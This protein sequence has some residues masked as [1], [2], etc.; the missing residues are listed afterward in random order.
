M[1]PD[2]GRNVIGRGSKN[3]AGALS[4]MSAEQ[5]QLCAREIRRVVD[6]EAQPRR[7][8]EARQLVLR[9][10]RRALGHLAQRPCRDEHA[11]ESATAGRRV[12]RE[13]RLAVPGLRGHDLAVGTGEKAQ[14]GRRD[15]WHVHPERD[16]RAARD[17]VERSEDPAGGVTRQRGLVEHFAIDGR[18][19]RATLRDDDDRQAGSASGGKRIGEQRAPVEQDARLRTA[20]APSGTAGKDRDNGARHGLHRGSLAARDSLSGVRVEVRLFAMLRER[21][22][23]SRIELE[24]PDGATVSDALRALATDGPLGGLI[25]LM[26]VRMAVNREYASADTVL[27]PHDELA[28]IPPVSGGAPAVLTVRLSEQPLSVDELR[29]AVVRPE[30]GAIVVFCGVTREVAS[31]Q[32]ESYREMAEEQLARIARECAEEHE[33]VAIAIEH[34]VGS[35]PLGEPSVVVA[36]SAAHRDAAFA[37]ARDAIDQVKAQ[38]TIW[39]R[40]VSWDGSEQWVDAQ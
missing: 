6:R 32:Y 20:E 2:R 17:A 24:L 34:R 8:A 10:C 36:V 23:S 18:E 28:L 30:A 35:V 31:L 12:A 9:E 37:G 39:K 3:P 33:L 22:G 15:E 26:P 14:Q 29:H 25:E 13:E 38:A 27:D 16:D 5:Q 19:L 40:Q 21:A 11:L 7:V 1:V 4:S